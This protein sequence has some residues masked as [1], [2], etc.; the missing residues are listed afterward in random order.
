ME[1]LKLPTLHTEE[2]EMQREELA[3]IVEHLATQLMATKQHGKLALCSNQPF[4]LVVL[5]LA[6]LKA[7][8]RFQPISPRWPLSKRG[9]LAQQVGCDL[10]W[11]TQAFN[12]EFP[13]IELAFTASSAKAHSQIELN[14][15]RYCSTLFTSGSTGQPKAVSHQ[16]KQHLAAAQRCNPTLQLQPDSC[17]LMSLPLYHAAGYAILMRCLVAGATIALPDQAGVTLEALKRMPVTHVSLVA[18]QL[19]RLLEHEEFH[20]DQL[21]LRHIMMGGGPVPTA[22]IQAAQARGFR[23]TFSYGMTETAAAIV[24]GELT[25]DSGIPLTGTEPFKLSQGEI[26]VTGPQVADHY[27]LSTGQKP[28]ANQQ[29]YFATGDLAKVESGKLYVVGRKDNRFISGGENIQP[30]LIE[31]ALEQHPAIA[32]ALV[33]PIADSEFGQRPVA[34]IQWRSSLVKATELTHWLR[35]KLPGFMCPTHYLAWPTEISSNQKPVRQEFIELAQRAY[36]SPS[37]RS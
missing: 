2:G 36:A 10:V 4:E 8:W 29:G 18:T 12:V 19:H 6:C 21:A 25:H 22:L 20:A 1:T 24:L 5:A 33:V 13:A 27:Q 3:Q 9:Q 11:P 32:V 34:F 26:L 37:S 28:L 30:E 15:E 23:L 16:L 35:E 7:G 31:A 14:P 17:W